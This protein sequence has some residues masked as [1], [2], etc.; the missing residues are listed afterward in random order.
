MTNIAINF[1]SAKDS[2]NT[3]DDPDKNML[4]RFVSLLRRTLFDN[5]G[6]DVGPEC[7]GTSYIEL[8]RE[9]SSRFGT[10][11]EFLSALEDQGALSSTRD[12][13]VVINPFEKRVEK[14]DVIVKDLHVFIDGFWKF[15]M[16]RQNKPKPAPEEQVETAADDD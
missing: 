14:C 16:K 8:P 1:S 11:D 4:T 2:N 7:R 10:D 3:D 9:K 6:E 12:K 15:A 5:P 13:P